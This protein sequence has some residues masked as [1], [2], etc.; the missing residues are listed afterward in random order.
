[1]FSFPLVPFFCFRWASCPH[2]LVGVG[3]PQPLLLVCWTGAIPGQ[4]SRLSEEKGRLWPG[5]RVFGGSNGCGTHHHHLTTTANQ[6]KKGKVPPC[7]HKERRGTPKRIKE[8]R[9]AQDFRTNTHCP[10]FQVVLFPRRSTESCPQVK[11]KAPP[12]HS[13]CLKTPGARKVK[14][15]QS[16]IPSRK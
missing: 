7:P 9:K 8:I 4:S 12:E 15:S 13:R 3:L 2:R 10:L 14:R 16:P 5:G 6:Q 11:A 1:M